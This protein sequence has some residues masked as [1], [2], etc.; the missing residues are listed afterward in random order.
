MIAPFVML[1]LVTGNNCP[2]FFVSF[3]L[4]LLAC[5]YRLRQTDADWFRICKI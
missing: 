1:Y 2:Y 4:V 3:T 5:S